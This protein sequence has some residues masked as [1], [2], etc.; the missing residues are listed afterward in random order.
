MV[1]RTVVV[2]HEV[3]LHARPA[4]LFVQAAKKFQS[5]IQVKNLTSGSST[6]NAKSII[7][8][9]TLGVLPDHSI[10]ITAS[11]ADEE[12]ALQAL[13]EMVER[14]FEEEKA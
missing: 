7:G 3:G 8:V 1:E 12:E 10:H 6:I 2:T 4:A 11:G 14:N 5:S 9:L 13:C